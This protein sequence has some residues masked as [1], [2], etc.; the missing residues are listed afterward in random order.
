MPGFGVTTRI[1]PTSLKPSPLIL[2]SVVE[3]QRI[4]PKYDPVDPAGDVRTV[5]TSAM[6]GFV[7]ED[8][9]VTRALAT[10]GPS[11]MEA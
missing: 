10:T 2:K 4:P 8:A 9:Y 6:Q 7:S 11:A 3:L 5:E 1:R